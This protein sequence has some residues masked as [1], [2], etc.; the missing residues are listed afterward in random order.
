MKKT[1]SQPL[2]HAA[3]LGLALSLATVTCRAQTWPSKPVRV[4]VSQAAGGTP[5]LIARL[6]TER[7]SR[8]L[9]QQ[10]VVE[11]RTGGSNIIGAQLA[12]R[13]PRRRL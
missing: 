9:G 8:D 7:M 3:L 1:S 11:N 10:F 12:A 6:V 4:I 2:F 13:A 5:D